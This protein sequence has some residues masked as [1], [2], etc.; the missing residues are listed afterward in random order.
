MNHIITTIVF[1]LLALACQAQKN[2]IMLGYGKGKTP[3]MN[4]QGPSFDL[5]Y[6]R[7]IA[8]RYGARLTIG[9]YDTQKPYFVRSTFVNNDNIEETENFNYADFNLYVCTRKNPQNLN[10]Y[11]GGGFTLFHSS[12]FGPT[13]FMPGGGGVELVSETIT[14]RSGM[15]N[16]FFSVNFSPTKRIVIEFVGQ[17]RMLHPY[18]D[19]ITY[20]SSVILDS[21][22]SIRSRNTLSLDRTSNFAL[23]LGYNF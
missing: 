3:L 21:S 16:S 17:V 22:S 20:S 23:R 10:F 19:P 12:Y 9:S 2:T 5:T 1:C 15:L 8:P 11:F 6:Q 7:M 4:Q 13:G 14:T 18:R